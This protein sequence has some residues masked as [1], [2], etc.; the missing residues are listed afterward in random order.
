[1][2]TFEKTY[3]VPSAGVFGGPTEVTIRPMT[4]KE[5]KIIYTS[6]DMSFI[7]KIVKSCIIEPKDVKIALLHPN[8][9]SFLLYMIRE[10][11][12]GPKYRQK[13]QCPYC[14]LQQDIEIDITEMTYEILDLDTLDEKLR[15]ELPVNK[16]I[17]QLKLLSQGD[18][19]EISNHIKR[20]EKQ[21]KLKDAEGYEYV[22]RF[23]KMIKT[24]NDEEVEDIREIVDYIED[25]NLR[26]FSAIKEALA[27][28][29][30]G[31]NTLNIRTCKKCGEE[32]EVYGAAVPEF[33]RT[34]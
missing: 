4:T 7:E 1:M 15:V 3:K 9:I 30:M 23:A 2:E 25:L 16:D 18:F 24:K 22:Y 21:G 19:E 33:F 20:L 26:D 11:T 29:P 28:I 31:L 6:R 17:I 14:G 10:L 8:E 12:F 5:E 34:N 32:V 13:M 27:N